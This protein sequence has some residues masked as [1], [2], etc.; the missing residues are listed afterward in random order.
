M[1]DAILNKYNEEV[2]KPSPSKGTREVGQWAIVLLLEEMTGREIVTD[3]TEEFQ[4]ELMWAWRKK[5]THAA[6]T[7]SRTMTVLSAAIGHC[8]IKD[9]PQIQYSIPWIARKLHIPTGEKRWF[10]RSDDD[11]ARFIDGLTSKAAF[12]WTMI[13][14]NTCCRPEAA[15]DLGPAQEDWDHGLVDL[16]PEGRQQNKKVRPI[17][18]MTENYMSWAKEI[19]AGFQDVVDD[20]ERKLLMRA[21]PWV[22]MPRYVPMRGVD[23][24]QSAYTRARKKPAVN[25]PGM[26]P[27]SI[28]HKM[29]SVLRSKGIPEEQIAR[30]VGHIKANT[31]TTMGYGEFTP[32]YLVDAANAIDEFILEL[33]KR[34]NRS[35]FPANYCKSTAS[36]NVININSRR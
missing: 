19:E 23:S 21:R 24:L 10:P 14:I 18:R 34:T 13:A 3:L 1:V 29:V 4:L 33:D 6:G 36:S 20:D 27:Y 8:K 16:N 15:L 31:R 17:V 22:L 7:I 5:H 11:L 12:H 9:A 35:L 25:L 26:V 28:R 32:D 30:Q 2:L